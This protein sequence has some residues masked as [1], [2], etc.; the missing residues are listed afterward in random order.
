MTTILATRLGGLGDLLVVL[1]A[2][3]LVRAAFPDRRIVLRGRP[4]YAALLLERGV[5][6][7]AISADAAE[8]EPD[9]IGERYGWFQRAGSVPETPGRYFVYDP[10]AGLPVGRYFFERTAASLSLSA[11]GFEAFAELPGDRPDRRTGPLI[12]HPGS[13][14][15]KKCWPLERFLA[16]AGALSRRGYAGRIVTGEVEAETGIV[17]RLAGADLPDGWTAWTHPTLSALASGIEAAPLYL[18]NDSGVT[19][20]AAAC[21]ARVLALFRSEF[22]PAWRPFGRTEVLAADEVGAI[23]LE[24]AV[25][26]AARLL[27]SG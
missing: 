11:A 19:H 25:E 21:G 20:L 23:P 8:T 3:R 13:G 10:A 26:A 6:D 24:D 16:L 4:G 18:G 27:P 7:E 17:G 14:S 9:G 15:A 5:V 12:V 2:L 1:P 22:V